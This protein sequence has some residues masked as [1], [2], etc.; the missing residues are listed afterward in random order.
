MLDKPSCSQPRNLLKLAR[1]FEKMG[2]PGV[3]FEAF[4]SVPNAQK[5]V[6]NSDILARL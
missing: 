3:D 4:L 5:V 6:V 1:L 2:R